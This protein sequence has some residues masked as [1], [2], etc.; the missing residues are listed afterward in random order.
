M[1]SIAYE[2]RDHVAEIALARAPVNALTADLL[3]ELIA[4]LDRA[5][6]DATVRAVILHSALE[7]RFCAG[8]DLAQVAAM[9]PAALHALI[10]KLYVGVYDAQSRLG[11]P[12]IAAVNGVARG[13]GMTLAISCDLIVADREATFG[14]PEI[15]IGVIPAIHY[16]HLTPIAGRYRTFDLLFTGRTFG[17]DEAAT[18]GLVSHV[19]DAGNALE[20]ARALARTLARKPAGAIGAGRAM[21]R[22]EIDRDYRE[23]V[24]LAVENF[25][26]LARGDEAREGIRAFLEKRSP[27]WA[28]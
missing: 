14:Y 9:P 19:A 12:S 20:Q 18:L 16:A 24:A 3:D 17:V 28:G 26:S 8:I 15:D 22:A 6:A 27:G 21:F 11:K 25:C 7:R 1:H 4:A 5:A 10:H 23:R 2:M 13:G